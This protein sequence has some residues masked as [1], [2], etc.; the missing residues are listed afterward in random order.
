MRLV[1][2]CPS[3]TE[4]IHYLGMT[5]HLVGIDNFSDWPNQVLK[6]PQ[7]GPDLNINMDKVEKLKPD[8]VVASLS[9]PGME[10][11]IEELKSRNIPYIVLNPNSLKDI[12]NEIFVL[13]DAL[14]QVEKANKLVNKMRHVI[15]FYQSKTAEQKDFPSVYWEWWPKP[16]FSPGGYNWLTEISE[17]AGGLN[18]FKDEKTA[19]VQTDWKTVERLNPDHICMVWVG[20]KQAKMNPDQIRKRPGWDTV[21][22]VKQ[23]NIHL[24]EEELFCRPSPRLLLGLKKIATV[25]HPE[26]F[27]HYDGVDPL[28]EVV[29]KD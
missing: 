1:S 17:L 13:G 5:D 19:S 20:V 15:E 18:I 7:L 6:L 10:R 4:L 22:A 12:Q 21:N 14:G 2:I 24:L 26:L 8:L 16:I 29:Q 11:N 9:V 3:N 23:N 27:P 25:L 28:L